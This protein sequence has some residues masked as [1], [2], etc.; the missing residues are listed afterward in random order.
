MAFAP[1]YNVRSTASPVP[2]VAV[3]RLPDALPGTGEGWKH[4]AL[5]A[6]GGVA[7]EGLSFSA[8]RHFAECAARV[9]ARHHRGSTPAV[10]Y[11]PKA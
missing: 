9:L 11:Y 10:R 3:V 1:H 8:T 5:D 7:G 4:F 2:S 6:A